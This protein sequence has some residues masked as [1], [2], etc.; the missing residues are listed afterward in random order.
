MKIIKKIQTKDKK[1]QINIKYLNCYKPNKIKVKKNYENKYTSLQ[2]SKIFEITLL[3]VKNKYKNNKKENNGKEKKLASIK[4]EKVN[5]NENLILAVRVSSDDKVNI[6]LN[7]NTILEKK[8]TVNL[9]KKTS[10]DLAWGMA[11]APARDDEDEEYE[12][13]DEKIKEDKEIYK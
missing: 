7:S 11:P 1:I 5:R 4:E 2:K 9:D 12:E 13:E 6:L 8:I 3:A 10:S